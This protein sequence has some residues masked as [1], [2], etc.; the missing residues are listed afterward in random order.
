M[1]AFWASTLDRAIDVTEHGSGTINTSP[2]KR[3]VLDP[4]G[5]T[6]FVVHMEPFMTRIDACPIVTV[7]EFTF[8]RHHRSQSI[9][10]QLRG[11]IEGVAASKTSHRSAA[12]CRP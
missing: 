1:Y 7:I 3:S 2:G 11:Q 6:F 10:E 12:R 4:G 8:M 5:L 9:V